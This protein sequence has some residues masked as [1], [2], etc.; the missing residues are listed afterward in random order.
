MPENDPD[1]TLRSARV[2]GRN[3]GVRPVF[4]SLPLDDPGLW[5]LL[6]PAVRPGRA[7]L[8]DHG[9]TTG[10]VPGLPACGHV[11]GG[12]LTGHVAALGPAGRRRAAFLGAALGYRWQDAEVVGSEGGV[13]RADCLL[14]P[15]A[16]ADSRPFD[17]ADF[18]ARWRSIWPA[19]LTEIL[20]EEGTRDAEWLHDRLSLILARAAADHAAQSAPQPVLS[21]L[22]RG[23]VTVRC[24]HRPYSDFF[25]MD[26]Y[27][28]THRRFDGGET[29]VL[30][31]AVFVAGDA[32]TVLP[33][34]PHR[35]RVLVVEQ[36]RAGPFGRGD[37]KP[38]ILE[39]VAGR[40]EPGQTPG[41]TAH[42]ECLE[43]AG[44][45][46]RSLHKVAEYYPSTGCFTEYVHSYIGL[47]DLP[48]GA[49]GLNGVAGEGEDIRGHLLSRAALM[50]GVRAG[51]MPD[52]PLILTAL[53]LEANLSRLSEV[54]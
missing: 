45:A 19:A 40:I 52:A 30:K 10:H 54:G 29:P 42:K 20:S 49:A 47:A 41:E 50:A 46:L 27:E 26:D 13:Q 5:A 22:D 39:P 18:A 37:P 4:L 1:P 48:D 2:L 12:T 51:E 34:D 9:L 16:A 14:P 28:I 15:E 24:R 17:M 6:D 3:A 21:G 31:R 23:D 53:W 32:V 8:W 36:F 7:V 11:P 44:L 33:Y 43:E 38:W 25:A 35:D